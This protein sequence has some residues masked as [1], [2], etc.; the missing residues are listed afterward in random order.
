MYIYSKYIYISNSWT[1][2]SRNICFPTR[3]QIE[4]PKII[5]RCRI[6]VW[7]TKIWKSFAQ[8]QELKP[9]KSMKSLKKEFSERR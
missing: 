1:V 3:G 6:G 8:K 5:G 2:F 7:V 9:R 4:L